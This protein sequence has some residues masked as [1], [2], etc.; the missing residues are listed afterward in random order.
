MKSKLLK[1]LNIDKIFDHLSGYVENRLKMFKLQ[2]QEDGSKVLSQ[3]LIVIA[4]LMMVLWLCFFLSMTVAFLIG[5]LVGSL[6][7]GFFI[8]S[9]CYALVFLFVYKQRENLKKRISNLVLGM[10]MKNDKV[11]G[12]EKKQDEV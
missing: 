12:Q 3:V 9:L 10:T 5:E 2:L 11:T 4:Q 1:L 7:L 8:L 6:S